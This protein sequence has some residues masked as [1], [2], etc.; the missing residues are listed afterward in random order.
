MPKAKR[1]YNGFEFEFTKRFVKNWST[2][3][4]Y[5]YSTLKGNY[6]GLAN[7]DESAATGNA[8]TSPNVNRIFDSLFML[9]DQTGTRQVE[10]KLGGDR[11]T[12]IGGKID[13]AKGKIKQGVG[14][15][16]EEV[17]EVDKP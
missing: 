1:D 7:S 3:F 5:V 16:K 14:E 9:Y 15:V 4:S 17:E 6:S 2:H 8:R 10:G 13:Q 12:E 11:S